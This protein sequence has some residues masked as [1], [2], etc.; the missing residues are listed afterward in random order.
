MTESHANVLIT[1]VSSGIGR[2]LADHYLN[3]GDSVCGVSRRT[4][5]DL[6]QR[7]GFRF[8]TLDLR[9]FDQFGPILDRLL[10]GLD[11]LDLVVLNAGVLGHFGDLPD[12]PLADLKNTFDINLWANK[13]L[14]DRLLAAG[15]P[16]GQVVAISS[17]ASVNGH[18]G[19]SGYSL[20]KAALNMLI[21]L[22]STAQPNSHITSLAP[23]VIDT[24]IQDELHDRPPDERYPSLEALRSKRGTPEM[25]TAEVAAP[26]IAACID[27]LPELVSSGDYADIRQLP[28]HGQP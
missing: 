28:G 13:M 4:P 5:S 21:K 12:T 15:L 20:S 24:E 8:E 25:P 19:W 17:G 22:V 14:L 6:C 1:G 9:E 16:V 3:R 10:N 2:A 23:G 11:R 18:R 27:Q 7:E 26:A